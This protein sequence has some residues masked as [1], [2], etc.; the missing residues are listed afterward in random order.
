MMV[1][2]RQKDNN[3]LF[4]VILVE[5]EKLDISKDFIFQLNGITVLA[6]I[7]ISYSNSKTIKYKEFKKIPILL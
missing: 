1:M 3:R 4:T 7:I 6:R 5:S 2:Q